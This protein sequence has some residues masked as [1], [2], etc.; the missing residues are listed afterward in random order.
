VFRFGP[1]LLVPFAP[2]RAVIYPVLVFSFRVKLS[3]KTFLTLGFFWSLASANA[4][5]TT[6]VR[7]FCLRLLRRELGPITLK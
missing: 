3:F 2:V 6:Y 5:K 7:T 1:G 4:A